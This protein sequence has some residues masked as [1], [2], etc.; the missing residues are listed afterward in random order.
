MRKNK[1]LFKKIGAGS[2]FILASIIISGTLPTFVHAE[3]SNKTNKL[4]LINIQDIPINS[5][6]D[7][8]MSY[9]PYS[10]PKKT[11]VPA[12]LFE[13]NPVTWNLRTGNSSGIGDV[14]DF[15]DPVYDLQLYTTHELIDM[16]ISHLGSNFVS[17]L[18][19]NQKFK[20]EDRVKS[21]IIKHTPEEREKTE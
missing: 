7:L 11:V 17:V 4:E 8:K 18:P 14:M 1:L 5:S 16:N 21:V 19:L 9:L 3:E 13:Q 10:V 20:A 6:E 12:K 2:K 15:I